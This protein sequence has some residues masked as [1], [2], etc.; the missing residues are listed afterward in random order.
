MTLVRAVILGVLTVVLY[1]AS[2]YSIRVEGI[3]ML[4][5]YR[6]GQRNFI[7]RLAYKRYGPQRGDVVGVRFAGPH[8]MYLKRVVGLP[9]EKVWFSK[10]HVMVNG[11]P[12]PEPYLKWPT[13]WESEPVEL[14]PDDFFVV[15]DN[16][17][18]PINQHDH[19]IATRER[20]LGK[21]LL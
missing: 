15:G 14:G 6:D 4:P 11:A 16:R 10:G 1:K 18:M 7:F 19:G 8:V 5:N 20:I 12:I 3:S 9:G 21:L 17:T 13:N 2:L